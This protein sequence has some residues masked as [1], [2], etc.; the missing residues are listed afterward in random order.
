MGETYNYMCLLSF[1]ATA[2]A[3]D[4]DDRMDSRLAWAICGSLE[5]WI[6]GDV[7]LEASEVESGEWDKVESSRVGQSGVG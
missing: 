4:G 3:S 5:R 6:G 7:R 1:E 2:V